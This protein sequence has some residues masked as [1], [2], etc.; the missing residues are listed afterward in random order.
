MIQSDERDDRASYIKMRWLTL[1]HV[2]LDKDKCRK[3][4]RSL[5]YSMKDKIIPY[6]LHIYHVQ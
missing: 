1:L 3:H 2:L 4:F 6:L 5:F